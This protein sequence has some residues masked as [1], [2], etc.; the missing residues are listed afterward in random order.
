M[1]NIYIKKMLSTVHVCMVLYHLKVL[2]TTCMHSEL[3]FNK[4]Y[5]TCEC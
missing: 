4:G 5:L 3:W 1:V 2:L